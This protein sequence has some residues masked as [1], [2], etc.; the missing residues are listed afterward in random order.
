MEINKIYGRHYPD[1]IAE[2]L[3]FSIA[4]LMPLAQCA[5]SLIRAITS[6][7]WHATVFLGNLE[8]NV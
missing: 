8:R 5:D 1:L 2:S 4:C 7:H 3:D 6:L